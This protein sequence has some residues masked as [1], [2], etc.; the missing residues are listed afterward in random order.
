MN[1]AAVRLY[2]ADSAEELY[3]KIAFDIVHPDNREMIQSRTDFVMATGVS[4]PLK[5]I[6]ILRRDGS[7]V[8]VEATAGVSY[9]R[10]RKVIQ[11]I[12]RD[13]TERKRAEEK[14]R[15]S[16]QGERGAPERDPPPCEE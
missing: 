4:A 15:A 8:D 14:I 11:V 6:R 13:I 16:L 12:Q 2:G 10:G 5:E 3:G 9:Y 1:P 7:A